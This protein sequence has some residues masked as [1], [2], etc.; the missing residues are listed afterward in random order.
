VAI[1]TAERCSAN[2][3]RYW[4]QHLQPGRFAFTARIINYSDGK[5]G[6][7][8]IVFRLAKNTMEA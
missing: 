2:L 4:K 6:D 7:R 5:P 3:Y 1:N 8:R